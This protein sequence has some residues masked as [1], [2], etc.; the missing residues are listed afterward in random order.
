MYQMT[1]Q[2]PLDRTVMLTR[3]AL[4]VGEVEQ[5]LKKAME[6]PMSS[7]GEIVSIY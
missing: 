1:P 5:H 2:S 3:D 6:V 7:P 4:S